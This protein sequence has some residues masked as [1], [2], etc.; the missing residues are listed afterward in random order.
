MGWA[1]AKCFDLS[2]EFALEAR[3]CHITSIFTDAQ[4]RQTLLV[5]VE[6]KHSTALVQTPADRRSSAPRTSVCALPSEL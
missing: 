2:F 1:G 4:P 6:R 5:L 3:C